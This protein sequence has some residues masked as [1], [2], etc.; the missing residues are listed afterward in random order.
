MLKINHRKSILANVSIVFSSV[1]V[2][3][4][5][6]TPFLI[7]LLPA[8]AEFFSETMETVLVLAIIPLSLVGFIPTW[9]RH[10]NY[11]LF[12]IFVLG[13]SLVIFS[14]LFIHTPHD[15]LVTHSSIWPGLNYLK[16]IL[17]FIGAAFLAFSVYKNNK[18]THVC[19][20]KH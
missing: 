15:S 6:M 12:R 3:H 11:A 2:L 14:Q 20:H 16:S 13:L 8:I 9:I 5:L 7:L 1:C 4:C 18:H 19:R 17:M 10:K